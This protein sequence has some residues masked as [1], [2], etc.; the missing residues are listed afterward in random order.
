MVLESHRRI[1]VRGNT[2]PIVSYL[3]EIKSLIFEANI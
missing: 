1:I 3:D 2:G